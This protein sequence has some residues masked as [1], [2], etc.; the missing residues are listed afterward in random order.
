MEKPVKKLQRGEFAMRPDLFKLLE[1]CV[2]NGV[3]LG[4]H[5]AY[6]HEEEPST[7]AIVDKI[8]QSVMAE[9]NEWFVFDDIH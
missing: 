4:V 9:I 6:K 3:K 2:E 8:T 1:Q 7:E 5:R